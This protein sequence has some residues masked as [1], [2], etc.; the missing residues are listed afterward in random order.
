MQSVIV[1]L[2]IWASLIVGLVF[3]VFWIVG[4]LIVGVVSV[5]DVRVSVPS[6]VATVPATSGRVISV[7]LSE[8]VGSFFLYEDKQG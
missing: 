4:P 1:V 6:N 8:P 2:D 5:F 7:L 3:P